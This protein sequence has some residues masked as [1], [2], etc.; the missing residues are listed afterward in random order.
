MENHKKDTQILHSSCF[1]DSSA[2]CS[3]LQGSEHSI[4]S[5]RDLSLISL[6][7]TQKPFTIY[8]NKGNVYAADGNLL[9]I[10]VKVYQEWM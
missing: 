10:Y 3:N 6:E 5:W 2:L 9:N 4:C 1:Y 7:E 8:A